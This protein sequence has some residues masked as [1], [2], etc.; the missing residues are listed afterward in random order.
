MG[1]D[2]VE[3]TKGGRVKRR[4]Y[5]PHPNPVMEALESASNRD[6][7]ERYTCSI[8][9]RELLTPDQDAWLKAHGKEIADLLNG[10]YACG[11][12]REIHE[13]FYK[14]WNTK[15]GLNSEGRKMFPEEPIGEAMLDSIN[16]MAKDLGIDGFTFG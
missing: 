7:C 14:E 9:R 8:I 13:K 12:E 11:L 16:K 5:V 3:R 4:T 10:R 2:I 1:K 15:L 6:D